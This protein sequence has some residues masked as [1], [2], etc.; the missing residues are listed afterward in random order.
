MIDLY[1]GVLD[2][3]QTPGT[4]RW[5]E[6]ADSS[7]IRKMNS[8][9]VIQIENEKNLLDAMRVMHHGYVIWLLLTVSRTNAWHQA[10]GGERA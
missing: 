5:G 9:Q 2:L 10:M 4:L 8:R 1:S 3:N 6:W 7:N